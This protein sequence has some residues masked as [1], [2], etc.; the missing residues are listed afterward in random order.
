MV[1]DSRPISRCAVPTCALQAL[2]SALILSIGSSLGGY[3]LFIAGLPLTIAGFILACRA[4]MNWS[5]P[6]RTDNFTRVTA[7]LTAMAAL[8]IVGPTTGGM[9]WYEVVKRT[10][11]VA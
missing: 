3:L 1:E 9:L 2:T 10:F 8:G 11:A 7:L 6:E 5:R 4:A